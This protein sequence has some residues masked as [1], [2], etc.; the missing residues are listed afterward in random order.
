MTSTG[1]ADALRERIVA[2]AADRCRVNV[3]NGALQLT[4]IQGEAKEVAAALVKDFK[5]DDS[6]VWVLP[7]GIRV[8]RTAIFEAANFFRP[9]VIESDQLRCEDFKGPE[10]ERADLDQAMRQWGALLLS[11]AVMPLKRFSFAEFANLIEEDVTRIQGHINQKLVS[12][13]RSL[14]EHNRIAVPAS[15]GAA[16]SS[17]L[18]M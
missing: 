17:G 18:S 10:P 1:R 4:C 15:P 6:G 3:Q 9:L 7:R 14:H 8:S 11:E 5:L 12:S 16:R 13:L 2:A